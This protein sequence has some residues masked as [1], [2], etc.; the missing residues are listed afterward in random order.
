LL[1]QGGVEMQ[2][3]SEVKCLVKYPLF[4]LCNG[5]ISIFIFKVLFLPG[6][7]KIDQV[8]SEVFFWLAFSFIPL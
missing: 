2:S 8:I 1:P 7:K 5:E 3:T 4:Y 6:A